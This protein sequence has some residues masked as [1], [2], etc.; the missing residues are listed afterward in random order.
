MTAW[1]HVLTAEGVPW[2][3]LDA[4][5]V[6]TAIAEEETAPLQVGE[7]F[8][9]PA[10]LGW[11]PEAPA[12]AEVPSLGECRFYPLEGGGVLAVWGPSCRTLAEALA[13]ERARLPKFVSTLTHELRLPLTSIKGYADLLVKGVMGPV[14]DPQKQFLE[15]I[16]N[17]VE[18][19]ATLIE[20]VSEMGKLESGR[21]RPKREPL[22]L[23]QALEAVEK[24]YRPR[25]EEK[26]QTLEVAV[27]A[28]LPIVLGDMPRVVQILEAMLDNAHKYTPEG[29]WISLQAEA[30]AGG[31]EVRVCDSGPGIAAEDAPRVFGAFFRSEIPEVRAHP[32]W[33]LS[34]HVAKQLAE[35]MGGALGF[36][37]RPE[38]G[39]CFWL[40]LQAAESRE[41]PT[42]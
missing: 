38:G 3:L 17:N 22:V 32:G 30:V 35:H 16:R 8:P 19:M 7:P 36:A 25:C 2:A 34:L 9:L 27:P 11:P 4:R 33:G 40:R 28:G 1:L 12:A 18:R 42:A 23:K 15:V 26:K 24:A 6:V 5:G 10:G 39:V 31:V 20:R 37:N 21:L 29:G 14:S 41:S 13:A